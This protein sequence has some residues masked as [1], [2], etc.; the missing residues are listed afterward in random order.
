MSLAMKYSRSRYGNAG[1]PG[2]GGFLKKAVGAV[3]GLVKAGGG[4]LPG[5]LGAIARIGGGVLAGVGAAST[6]RTVARTV[7]ITGQP[8]PI[9]MPG[10]GMVPAPDFRVGPV[11]VH[12]PGRAPGVGV[13]VGSTGFGMFPTD[14]GVRPAGYRPN[15]SDYFLR[16][17]TF[18]PAGTRMV[19]A[20]RRNPL[21]PRALDRAMGRLSSAKKAA[22]KINRITIRDSCAR[23]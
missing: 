2:L 18:V 21:N 9:S 3:G 20:R 14:G 15:K 1:D 4:I 23:K 22:K 6:A 17:G 7:G 11:G 13:S 10:V 19:K 16:D 5:P 12:V 8:T